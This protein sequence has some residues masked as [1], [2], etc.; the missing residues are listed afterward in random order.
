LKF[1][2]SQ[3]FL[4]YILALCEINN[5]FDLNLPDQVGALTDLSQF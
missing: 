5:P 2:L 3:L 1:S 4:T